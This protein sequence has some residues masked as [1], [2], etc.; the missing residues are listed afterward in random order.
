MRTQGKCI[1][2]YKAVKELEENTIEGICMSDIIR[3]KWEE[4]DESLR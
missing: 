1:I 3:D 2:A 4:S